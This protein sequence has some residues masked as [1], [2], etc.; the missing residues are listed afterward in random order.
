LHAILDNNDVTSPSLRTVDSANAVSPAPVA[1]AAAKPNHE[2]GS[3]ADAVVI[4]RSAAPEIST[5]LPGVS[6][7]DEPRFRRH[8]YR[9][10]I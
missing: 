5:R 8:M 4:Q 6:S 10:D 3:D 2:E 1:D 9:T 7:S